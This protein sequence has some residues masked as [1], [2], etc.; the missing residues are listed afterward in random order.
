M[1]NDPTATLK[2][3]LVT[4]ADADTL[5]KLR[6]ECGWGEGNI[7]RFIDNPVLVIYMFYYPVEAE[8]GEEIVAMGGLLLD[9]EAEPW[10]ASRKDGIVDIC[11]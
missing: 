3:R 4:P 9:V 11:E 1:P 10:V 2:H 5:L 7:A 8:G 6:L